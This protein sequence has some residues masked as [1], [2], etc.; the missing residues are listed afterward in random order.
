MF[1]LTNTHLFSW[2][3]TA[4]LPDPDNPGAILKQ[5][6][7]LKFE[8]LPLDEVEALEQ[9]AIAGT[10]LDYQRVVQLKIL[11]RA[12]KGWGDDVVDDHMQPV[13]FSEE[14]FH[15]ALQLA[16][17]RLAAINAFFEGM[18]GDQARLGN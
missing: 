4:S 6:F 16:W 5:S 8:A 10:S 11:R 13:P 9:E 12:V 18:R 14:T 17:F 3:A 7:T 2:P 15:Q 1:I